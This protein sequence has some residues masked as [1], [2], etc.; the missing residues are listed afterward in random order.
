[1]T[2][3]FHVRHEVTF[4][5]A[6]EVL[7]AIGRGESYDHV[8]QADR[9]ITR[10]RQLRLLSGDSLTSNG[11]NIFS[12]CETKQDL[13]SDLLHFSHYTLWQPENSSENGFAWTYRTF[14]D[15]IW[16]LNHIQINVEGLEPVVSKLIND[17]EAENEFDVEE[18][19]KAVVSLSW[20]SL[21]GVSNWL[22]GVIPPVIE[23]EHFTRRFFCPPELALLSA[24]WTAQQTDGEIGIDF[25]LTPERREMMCKVC[26]LDPSALDRVLDWTLPLYPEV[27]VDGTNA[28]VYGRFI[29]FLKWPELSDLLH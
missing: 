19:R 4:E 16:C 27:M 3:S 8:L 29:R 25:L 22:A 18:T 17:I 10:L 23:N 6:K 21:K 7:F 26:L 11:E 2:L 28:G 24:G 5:R 20:R 1:M 12:L 13:W 14:V 9:Q 15:H